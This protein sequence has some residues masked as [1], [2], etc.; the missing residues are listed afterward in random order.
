MLQP[1]ISLSMESKAELATHFG[2]CWVRTIYGSL[3]VCVELVDNWPN[4][5]GVQSVQRCTNLSKHSLFVKA[6]S[7]ALKRLT[8]HMPHHITKSLQIFSMCTFG[9]HQ[10][11]STSLIYV[12]F[13]ELSSLRPG[14]FHFKTKQHF[15]VKF[16]Q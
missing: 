15:L 16:N 14:S 9:A 10:S 8:W 4:W 11:T 6:N 13:S 7:R 5:M 1:Q 3:C 12:D 2:I